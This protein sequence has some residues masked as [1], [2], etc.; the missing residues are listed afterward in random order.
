MWDLRKRKAVYT[1]P[2]HTSL[3]STVRWQPG[4]GHTLL[5]TGYD[6]QAKL[7]S[8]RDWKLLKVLAGHE[9]KIM[10]ADL[11]PVWSGAGEGSG[12]SVGLGGQFDMLVGSVSYDRTIKV[13]AP[14]DVPDVVAAAESDEDDAGD[15]EF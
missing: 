12:H 11:C 6:C 15:M 10:A 1:I 3:V 5:T 9:G 2:A 8:S 14:E 7:W 4:S 13:W